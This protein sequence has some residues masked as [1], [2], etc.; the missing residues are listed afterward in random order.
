MFV[1]NGNNCLKYKIIWGGG[2]AQDFNLLPRL[3]RLPSQAV[4]MSTKKS[5]TELPARE[6]NAQLESGEGTSKYPIRLEQS[7]FYT[8]VG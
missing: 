7:C 6:V 2:E 4:A 5:M 3:Q 1:F 8:E